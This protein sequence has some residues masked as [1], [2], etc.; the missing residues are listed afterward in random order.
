MGDP[1]PLAT[2]KERIRMVC[3]RRTTGKELATLQ[4][5]ALHRR[6]NAAGFGDHG[7]LRAAD[8]DH[9]TRA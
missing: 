3:L 8:F 4:A 5:S 6:F 1:L 2:T 7:N 9:V